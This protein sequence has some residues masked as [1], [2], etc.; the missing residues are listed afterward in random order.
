MSGAPGSIVSSTNKTQTANILK[1]SKRNLALTTCTVL[2]MH[3][4]TNELLKINAQNF[5]SSL[6]C[7]SLFLLYTYGFSSYWEYSCEFFF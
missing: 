5:I 3:F 7:F 1:L 6:F 4:L 2:E